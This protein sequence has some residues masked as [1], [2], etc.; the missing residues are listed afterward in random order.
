MNNGVIKYLKKL[1]YTNISSTYY[2][3]V[4]K[5]EEWYKNNVDFHDYK[6]SYGKQRK[7]YTLGM[8][9]KLSE[10]WASVIYSD[11]DEIK[12]D[13]S[14][15]DNFINKL[16]G[17]LNLST[18]I[19]KCIEKSSWSGTCGAVTRLKNVKIVDGKLQADNKTSRELITVTAKQIIP[20]KVEHGNIIDVAIVSNSNV[21]DKKTI[22]IELHALKE[23]GYEI[24]NIYIDEITGKEIINENVLKSFKTLSNTPLFSL[25][26]PPKNNPIENNNGL[27]FSVYG[28]AIDQLK[29]CDITYHNFMMDFALGGKKIIYNKKLVK[30]KT[31][32]TTINGVATTKEVPIYPDD[33]LKQQFLEIGDEFG[34][35]E[36]ELIHEYN[37]ALRVA[38][39][40][41]GIQFAL[42]ILSFKSMLGV[43]RYQFSGGSIVTATQ[44]VGEQ[45][46]LI[47]NARKYRDNL[48]KFISDIIKA[49]LLLGR[50]VFKEN[51]TEDCVVM[52]DNVDGFMQDE[53]AIKQSAREDLAL[54]VISK[55]EYRMIVYKETEEEAKNMLSKID[56]ENTIKTIDVME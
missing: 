46:D 48:S 14:Q 13:K 6:D 27:G 12:T 36:K 24:S 41:D 44:Y 34:G 11:R 1:G 52:I 22:Y 25:L 28:D 43:K 26:M 31:V 54:G 53:E 32:N 49:N 15:N 42:D 45:Q 37:P 33:T 51:V 7:M 29:G 3:Y 40:K 8:A 56:E 9:K 30:Y 55:L 5:W 4:D 38:D 17:E 10:D 23:D 20:L 16:I 2:E 19:P 18:I 47:Q 39:N 35:T 50:L 21:G